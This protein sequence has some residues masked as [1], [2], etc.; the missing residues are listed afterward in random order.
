MPASLGGTSARAPEQSNSA[1]AY[2]V[3]RSGYAKLDHLACTGNPD[4]RRGEAPSNAVDWQDFDHVSF[5]PIVLFGRVDRT[6]TGN[7]RAVLLADRSPVVVR[8]YRKLVF[9]PFG[10]SFNHNERGQ[11]V[12]LGDSSIMW[13]TTPVT[14]QGDNIWLSKKLEEMIARLADPAHAEPISGTKF[15]PPGKT[16]KSAPERLY[17]PSQRELAGL[18]LAVYAFVPIGRWGGCSD[19]DFNTTAPRVVIQSGGRHAQE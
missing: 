18:P 19:T 14:A 1:N 17:P 4:A 9:N 11:N 15:R 3:I 6:A 8:S 10:N 7:A 16:A 2:S 12:L 13:M 5:S